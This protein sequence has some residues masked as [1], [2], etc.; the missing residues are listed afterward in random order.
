[1]E[2]SNN[3]SKEI[4]HIS[5]MVDSIENKIFSII[6]LLE[7]VEAGA[8]EIGDIEDAYEMSSMNVLKNYLTLLN[9]TDIHELQE[10]VKQLKEDS[11]V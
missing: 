11:K 2:N 9:K 8:K 6:K 7:L 3:R 5:D 1:M 10:R 4:I